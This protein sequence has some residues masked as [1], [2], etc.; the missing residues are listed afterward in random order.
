MK[1]ATY[2]QW[3]WVVIMT[4][5]AATIRGAI[6]I[7]SVIT[8]SSRCANS[9]SIIVY[10]NSPTQIFYRITAGPEIRPP[11]SGANF[12]ALPAGNYT[13]L[14]T[15]FSNDSTTVQ[16][17][18][19]GQYQ[20]PDFTPSWQNPICLAQP[21]TGM[22]VGNR[23]TGTG[24]GPY[25]WILTD[26]YGNN[27]P[28]QASDT[29]RNLVPGTYSLRLYDSCNAYATR[30]VTLTVPN[31]AFQ[32]QTPIFINMVAC[33]TAEVNYVVIKQ[34]PDWSFPYY[35]EVF[36]EGS[37]FY[38]TIWQIPNGYTQSFLFTYANRVPL[39]LGNG[40]FL[41]LTSACGD[42]YWASFQADRWQGGVQPLL[43]G[44]S[45]AQIATASYSFGYI[46]SYTTAFHAPIFLQ[47]VD[48]ATGLRVDTAVITTNSSWYN[49]PTHLNRGGAY[50]MR[51]YDTCGNSCVVPFS[52]GP[53]DTVMVQVDINS[54]DVCQDSVA[55]AR[56]TGT[57]FTSG[58]SLTMLSGPSIAQS[59]KPMF[60]HRD[61]IIYP[62]NHYVNYHCSAYNSNFFCF[63]VAGLAAGTY[64]FRVTDSC[65]HVYN[66]SFT[67]TPAD[68]SDYQFKT[69][70][71]KG[72]PGAN[73]LSFKLSNKLSGVA[74]PIYLYPLG[75]P[76][77]LDST[78]AD[79][80][81]FYNLNARTYLLQRRSYRGNVDFINPQTGCNAFDDTIVIPPYQLPKISYATQVKCN[82]TVNVGLQA[83]SAFGVPPYFYEIISGPQQNS[84]QADP[85]FTLNT[86]GNYIARISDGCGFARTFSFFVDT[87]SFATPVKAG[88]FCNGSNAVLF[89]E[90]SP[91][92]SYIWQRPN[93]SFYRGDTLRLQPIL[94][95]DYGTYHIRKIVSV[96]NCTDTFYQN[97]VIQ[98]INRTVLF[99][100]LCQGG[101]VLFAGGYRNA[102][103]T[104]YDTIPTALCD[105]IVQLQ[106]TVHPTS[107]DSVSQQLC[108]GQ[109][110]W[111][112][113]HAY[114]TSGIY[115]DTFT[116]Q[117]GCDSIVINNLQFSPITR[118]DTLY[119]TACTA[120]TIGTHVY[121]QS[122][123]YR[124]TLYDANNCAYVLISNLVVRPTPIS[125]SFYS[126]CLGDSF[127]V[128][129]S[130]IRQTTITYHVY[131]GSYCGDSAHID[132]YRFDSLKFGYDTIAIC[133]GTSTVY[134]GKLI[135]TLG[136][137]PLDTVPTTSCDSVTYLLV[138]AS[139]YTTTN[140]TQTICAGSSIT[141]GSHTYATS[142]IYRDTFTTSSCDSIHIL[143]LT[144]TPQKRDS[145]SLQICAGSS[146][147][148][149]T[150]TYN[151]SGIYRDTFT[152]SSCDSIHILNLT[153]T[154]QKRDSIVQQIC[155]GSSI[156]IG[157][158]TYAT[159]GI[160]R[161]T[162]TTASC[163]SIHILNLT[164]TPQKRDSIVLQICAGSSITI[165]SH[166]YATS[167]IYRDTFTTASCDSIHILNLTVTPQ[168]RDSI[169]LQICAG[170]S[171]TIGSH[172]YATSGI[173]RDTFTTS[174]CDSIHILN[175]TV[176]PQKRDSIVQ[177]IC[178]GSSITTGTHTYATSGI[179]RDT[180]TTA[181][182]D[183]IHI[184]NLTVTPQKRDSI[185]LQICAGSSITIGSHTYATS[186][187]Y[188]DT[189]TTSSCDS[190]H[191]LNLTVT[192][193]KRDS[194]S[195]QI[196]AG[197]SI[198]IGS[199][200][201]AT[202]GIYRDTITT[203][204]CDSI[205]ILNLTVSPQKR[206]SIVQQIC[207]GSSISI[208]SHTYATSGIYRDT[209]T[210]SSC[211][212]I[213]ILNLTVSP[214]PRDT[215]LVNFCE[216]NIIYL[217]N[218]PYSMPGY[219]TDTFANGV[220]DS[221]HTWHLVHFP[222]PSVQITSSELFVESGTNI[223]LQANTNTANSIVWSG[224]ANATP[225]AFTTVA[226]ITKPVWITATVT[227]PDQ[228]IGVD[229][230]YIGHSDCI[231]AIYV[232]NAFT[233]NN[234]G[235]NDGYRI[236]GHCFR[237][238]V[239]Q[240]FNRWGEKVWETHDMEQAWN[241][242]YQGE[243]QPPG[244][245]VYLLNYTTNQSHAETHEMKG[246]ITLIR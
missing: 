212:S 242:Y 201:Y 61:T 89:S 124:D 103:G 238:N 37:Y 11:Q 86:Q 189:I 18:V 128:D 145:V 171:I 229:S 184:L 188:R 194:V 134:H 48:Q 117:L 85:F 226:T 138:Q 74:A 104:Y 110:V 64:T 222:K 141:I 148:I 81:T 152:T 30:Q 67:V 63:T 235:S 182:C 68:L 180:F 52:I 200:T 47:V 245:F 57:G 76:N 27:S 116:S 167:G 29:F 125:I 58:I 19:S 77:P 66:G 109:I 98:N 82:G 6:G 28:A 5:A 161:D 208:G 237:L 75:N 174:S 49:S 140:T 22:I 65:Y 26:T 177:Q 107:R 23:D 246:S 111:V 172:T 203:S 133:P 186:G 232:P 80:L 15:N 239:L 97:Y 118:F 46:Y 151:T 16:A 234:D 213:H 42:N 205:H 155:A 114:T 45:C 191:I 164:V 225:N 131:P 123:T 162:F 178:A 231:T 35:V 53:P 92:A 112:G 223:T 100:T 158:H 185:V 192:N 13:V 36:A 137:M 43:S 122:G 146:I 176:S 62:T 70:I 73:Q 25:Y 227:S 130:Y 51:A 220:C 207:A 243:L 10:A 108:Y 78:Y 209:I 88:S 173:Y 59:T 119:D 168:K 95:G 56:I 50:I 218:R 105:S 40:G 154:P 87:L 241:G 106:L 179:Y 55:A 39:H 101:A 83:D 31:Y 84:M 187:I 221:L 214:I 169:V 96:N 153:V 149:G 79:T 163:D 183:S 21:A 144:V 143:N 157:S 224:I 136:W 12:G 142:G 217:T 9:G 7:D 195:L 14:L 24:I 4:M 69:N 244:V 135:D 120:I 190:I 129:S 159:S 240:I 1:A 216:G 210:T 215:T 197:S 32:I 126:F 113:S 233:P 132:F 3:G 193:Q 121:T 20:F 17:A 139:P 2:I 115:R 33:D 204:S 196:C 206:D 199:H 150:H 211:D 91:Y 170:S 72:C 166:T 71:K 160:Y 41:H 181:S 202:S 127:L 102:S 198:S 219:Y 230:I 175:L 44:D 99:D 94:A 147:S 54:Y 8:T 34:T 38:D 156:T 60:Q 165:G 236:Y 93:G 228:C 90:P